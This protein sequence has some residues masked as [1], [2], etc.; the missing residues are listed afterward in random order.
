MC[1]GPGVEVADALTTSAILNLAMVTRSVAAAIAF[2]HF[3][4][5]VDMITR[6]ST[7]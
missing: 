2:R 6:K 4:M 7:F 3:R 5:L 1:E